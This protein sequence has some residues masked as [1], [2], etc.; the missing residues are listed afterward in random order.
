MAYELALERG[1]TAAWLNLGRTLSELGDLGGELWAYQQSDAAGDSGGTLALAFTLR[2]Q[3]DR[4][5]AMAAAERSAAA[6]NVMAAAVVA[7]WSG[8]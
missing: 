4:E 5:A 1:E 3:G 7:C 8:T 2:E 6:G